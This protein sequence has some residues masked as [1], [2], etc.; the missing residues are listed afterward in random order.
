MQAVATVDAMSCKPRT[1]NLSQPWLRDVTR[2]AIAPAGALAQLWKLL[3]IEPDAASK[4]DTLIATRLRFRKGA[5]LFHAGDAFTSLYAIRSGSCKTVIVSDGQDQVVGY[6][7]PGDLL[8]AHG[9]GGG[10]HS[11][12]AIA[13]EDTEVCVLPFDRIEALARDDETFQ[14]QFYRILAREMADTRGAVLTLGRARAEQRLAAFLLDLARR[15]AQLGYS[16]SEFV[17]RM[18]R[19]EIGSHLGLTLETISRLFS[20][21][22]QLGIAKVHG[23]VIKIVDRVALQRLVDRNTE[24]DGGPVAQR[25]PAAALGRAA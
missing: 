14:H 4:W 25:I 12:R 18:T 7:M 21:F 20:R 6:H 23:R 17:L 19:E 11:C 5:T 13:L 8:G 1:V 10:R 22:H 15:Y 9:I 3:G 24:A 16:S 2:N